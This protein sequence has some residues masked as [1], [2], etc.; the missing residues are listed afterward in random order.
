MPLKSTQTKTMRS[1]KPVTKEL[2]AE[3]EIISPTLSK[4]KAP[5]ELDEPESL[6]ILDE[7]PETDP[8]ATEDEADESAE[9]A[10][11]EDEIDPFGDKWE[12]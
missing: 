7:K 8:L 9:E 6:S 3:E 4:S 5:I 11:I 1:K 10:G 2:V 12:A